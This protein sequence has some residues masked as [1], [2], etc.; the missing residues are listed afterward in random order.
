MARHNRA[1]KKIV[2]NM[3][4]SEK[5]E[6]EVFTSKERKRW[7]KSQRKKRRIIMR[8]GKWRRQYGIKISCTQSNENL[9]LKAKFRAF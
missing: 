9:N 1:R 5:R 4:K 6:Y 2:K 7:R 3:I 8:S